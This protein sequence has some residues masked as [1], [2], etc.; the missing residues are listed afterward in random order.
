MWRH[1]CQGPRPS[2][3]RRAAPPADETSSATEHCGCPARR[4]WGTARRQAI[5]RS[6]QL[7]CGLKDRA[8]TD[9]T[10]RRS[11]VTA[12]WSRLS[13]KRVSRSCYAASARFPQ[14]VTDTDK[15]DLLQA[16]KKTLGAGSLAV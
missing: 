8:V 15:C 1:L 14:N 16:A 13:A 4:G 12:P 10:D 9:S 2:G 3:V 5:A 7:G 6:Q 11:N